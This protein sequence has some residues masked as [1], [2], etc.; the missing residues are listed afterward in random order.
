MGTSFAENRSPVP[1]HERSW[2]GAAMYNIYQTADGKHLTLGGSEVKFAEN[3]LKALERE[4]LLPLCKLPPGDEQNPVKDFFRETFTRQD[5]AYWQSFLANV[6]VCWSP[7]RELN[8][9]IRDEH[10]QH[11]DMLLIDEQ[12]NQHLGVPIKFAQEPA[13]PDFALP[14]F[15]QDTEY[16]LTELGYDQQQIDKM[17][18]EK[19]FI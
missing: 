14:E 3:L 2:G 15:S 9:A 1:K 11:R 7:V 12:G 6:D 16:V 18:A 5:L 10:L 4:D 17:R 13:Q 19:T 8:E